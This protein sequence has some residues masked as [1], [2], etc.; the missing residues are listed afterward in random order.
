MNYNN[1]AIS[2]CSTLQINAKNW[3]LWYYLFTWL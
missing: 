1:L 3:S 2:T